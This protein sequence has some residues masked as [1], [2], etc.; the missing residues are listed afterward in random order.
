MSYLTDEEL[1]ALRSSELDTKVPFIIH[2]VSQSPF[3]ESRLSGACQ[4]SNWY[5][6][7]IPM[8][9]ELIRE[10]VVKWITE[11]RIRRM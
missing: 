5:Y 1:D 6:I 10:D 7:Y 11:R 3:S 9:D 2:G 4:Y 8:T